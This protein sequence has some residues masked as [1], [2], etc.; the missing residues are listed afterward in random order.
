MEQ[1]DKKCNFS[2]LIFLSSLG[3][4]GISVS[5]FAFFNYTLEHGKGLIKISQTH[6]ILSGFQ[7]WIYSILEI[8]MAFFVII[9]LVLTFIFF[10]KMYF[11]FKD[12][13]IYNKFINNPL[14]NS[15]ILAPF[16]SITMTMNVFIASI[17][18]FIPTFADNL[19]S[20]MLSGLITWILIWIFLMR[21][22]IKLLKISFAQGFDMSKITFGWLL[23]PFALGM[24]SV[25][26]AGIAALAKN[27]LI[28]DIAF[29][30]LLI[31]LTMGIFLF[32]V[33][34]ISIFQKHFK[35]DGL[36]ERKFLPS[37][38]II[39]PN[40]TL[41][42]ITF[43]RLGHFLEHHYRAHFQIFFL[44]VILS[45]FAF[46]TWYMIFGISLLKDYFKKDLFNNFHVSQ[47][48]LICP[49]VA[50][51]VISSFS[52]MLFFYNIYF[53]IFNVLLIV[54]T[55]ILFIFLFKK[56]IQCI[57]KSNNNLKCE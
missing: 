49:F 8:N 9:H 37:L 39:I 3:A 50:Y 31:S 17:R 48:G 12:K 22:E 18:Y 25:T 57:N 40:I 10:K 23:H 53:L 47:W 42:A 44:L 26:G 21:M 28:S 54:F 56:Q 20:F 24:I 35:S 5:I 55:I 19:Q 16:L 1:K 14:S 51:S 43:F 33:K 32:L 13:E 41:F 2:P 6:Q 11:W 45:A 52:Y 29:F 15:A 36:G 30:F 7:E 34:L 38:L 4:G 27:K 46:E